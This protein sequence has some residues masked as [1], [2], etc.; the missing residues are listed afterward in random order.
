MCGVGTGP[1]QPLRVRALL[2][3]GH[4]VTR[5][6]SQAREGTGRSKPVHASSSDH[7]LTQRMAQGPEVPGCPQGRMDILGALP[8]GGLHRPAGPPWGDVQGQWA[9]GSEGTRQVPPER[10][11]QPPE[12]PEAGLCSPPGLGGCRESKDSTLGHSLGPGSIRRGDRFWDPLLPLRGPGPPPQ[13][14]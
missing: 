14:P 12:G 1:V 10:A 4:G 9:R 5:L 8:S 3:A 11:D 7:E 6:G 2:H 13:P